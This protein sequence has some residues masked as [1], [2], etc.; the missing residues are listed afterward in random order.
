MSIFDEIIESYTFNGSV[1]LKALEDD[2]GTLENQIDSYN[3]V[4]AEI[5]TRHKNPTPLREKIREAKIKL[6]LLQAVYKR[7]S[8]STTADDVITDA[9]GISAKNANE[10]ESPET[11]ASSK[12]PAE[13]NFEKA[14]TEDAQEARRIGAVGEAERGQRGEGGE[15]IYQDV[16]PEAAGVAA[17]Q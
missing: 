3:A 4:M 15:G 8:K 5:I 9:L 11:M 14:E 16:Q 6:S 17:G 7:V 1:S 12:K 2:I 13:Q 10:M